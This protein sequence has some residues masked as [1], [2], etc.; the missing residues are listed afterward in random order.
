MSVHLKYESRERYRSEER[1]TV[2][3]ASVNEK[4]IRLEANAYYAI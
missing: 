4:L 2:L 1:F 3:R